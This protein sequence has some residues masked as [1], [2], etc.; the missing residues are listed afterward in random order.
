ML[1]SGSGGQGC[2]LATGPSGLEPEPKAPR[3]AWRE[4]ARHP[5][6]LSTGTAEIAAST[7]NRPTQELSIGTAEIAASTTNRPTLELSTGTAEIA[8][9]T[10]NR[11]TQEL[12]IGTADIAA[13]TIHRHSR[14]HSPAPHSISL[15]PG[16]L[17]QT[18]P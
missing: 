8:A 3:N 16:F 7:T 5:Q 18:I 13:S 10:T 4:D 15:T 2:P 6:G 12:S 11:L 17:N 14:Y 9:S 1:H